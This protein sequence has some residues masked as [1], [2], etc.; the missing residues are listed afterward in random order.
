MKYIKIYFYDEESD[1]EIEGKFVRYS[2]IEIIFQNIYF[3]FQNEILANDYLIQ[4]LKTMRFIKK[5]LNSIR[6]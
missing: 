6:L 1:E 2:K 3:Q 5:K 4:E